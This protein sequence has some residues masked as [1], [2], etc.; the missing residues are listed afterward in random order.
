MN[1]EN[2]KIELQECKK[3]FV[4]EFKT[5]DNDYLL[6][7]IEYNEYDDVFLWTGKD[8]IKKFNIDYD[9]S[10]DMN[11]QALYDD[12]ISEYINIIDFEN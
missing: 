10:L 4:F 12:V 8:K 3:M 1:K 5:I 11:L 9:F 6:I 2:F 7:D